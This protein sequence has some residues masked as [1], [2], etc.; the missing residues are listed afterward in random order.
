V[1]G[2]LCEPWPFDDDSCC[3]FIELGIAP[4]VTGLALEAASEALWLATGQRF[5]NCAVTLRP[6][7]RDCTDQWPPDFLWSDGIVWNHWGYPWP[8]LVGGV[9]LNLACGNCAGECSCTSFSEILLPDPV[10][11]VVS[12]T[13]DG[14][15]L[16]SGSDYLV[17]DHQRLVRVG[18]EWPRCQNYEVTGGPGTLLLEVKF[19]EPVPALGQLAVAKYACELA[20][21][22]A[23]LECELPPY[24]T[25]VTRQGVTFTLDP[26]KLLDSGLTGVLLPDLFIRRYNPRGLMDRARAYSPDRPPPRIV[27]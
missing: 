16:A 17:Y 4:A 27:G 14:S 12:V 25:Q 20:K 21:A 19:G 23:G 9:W 2:Y 13:L 24:V 3:D 8:A 18:A 7:R 6:C 15:P 22:C 5:G 10:H 1:Y 11:E 26:V